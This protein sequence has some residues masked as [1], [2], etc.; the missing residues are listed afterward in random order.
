MMYRMCDWDGNVV[1]RSIERCVG[2]V[3]EARMTQVWAIAYDSAHER[4]FAAMFSRQSCRYCNNILLV[5]GIALD[6]M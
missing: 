4:P 6:Q 3:A 5:H 2:M 1:T